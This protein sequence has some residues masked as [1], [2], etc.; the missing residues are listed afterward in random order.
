MRRANRFHRWT[1]PRRTPLSDMTVQGPSLC[2]DGFRVLVWSLRAQHAPS[3]VAQRKLHAPI[4]ADV[5]CHL[6]P[7]PPLDPPA[8]VL[9]D[10]VVFAD[11]EPSDLSEWD[12]TRG[13]ETVPHRYLP[14]SDLQH[15]FEAA[16][17]KGQAQSNHQ[18]Q[19][20]HPPVGGGVVPKRPPEKDLLDE[21]PPPEGGYGQ[22]ERPQ[23]PLPEMLLLM[24]ERR[25]GN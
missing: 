18:P 15:Q 19:Q 21:A 23:P 16:E 9:H 20:P 11:L 13:Q 12:D 17:E 14:S 25:L 4:A 2:L 5:V 24:V 22:D 10:R 6:S 7:R 8:A 3:A 1:A